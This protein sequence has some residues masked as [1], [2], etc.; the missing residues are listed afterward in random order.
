MTDSFIK[1]NPI[2]I[3]SPNTQL[4]IDDTSYISSSGTS[5]NTQGSDPNDPPRWGA[6][7]AGSGG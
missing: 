3:D 7:K 1:A 5:L 6:T 4:Y 2:V